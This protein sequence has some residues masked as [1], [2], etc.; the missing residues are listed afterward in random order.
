MTPD[1]NHLLFLAWLIGTTLLSALIVKTMARIGVMDNP[2]E[3]SSH[4]VPT[5][6]GG[7]IGI[8]CAFLTGSIVI[9]PLLHQPYLFSI[10]A[11]LGTV[12]FLSIIS[13][14]DDIKQWPALIKLAA[15]IICAITIT[16]IIPSLSLLQQSYFLLLPIILIWL[17]Y[18][19]NAFNFMDGLNGLA[20]G[21]AAICCIFFY[22]STHQIEFGLIALALLC[23]LI[24]FLPFNYPK[25]E[26]FM[27]DVGSQACGLLLATFAVIPLNNIDHI[28]LTTIPTETILI[29]FL[30]FGVIYDVTFTLIRRTKNRDPILQAHR[31]H[32][33]QMAHRCGVKAAIVTLVQWS[34]CIWGGVI[35]LFIPLSTMF[36]TL[37]AYSLLIVPQLIWTLF[38]LN[39]TRQY[40]IKKW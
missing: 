12:A 8:I 16:L 5:P 14:L 25:A 35:I 38:I 30:L 26:I 37:C 4:T 10:I 22:Y 34:F 15:Q 33:Y 11:L 21:I 1:T 9:F 40:H 3:R 17:V 27:G 19:V 39:K 24:G 29:F 18:I 28:T 32:L 20:A 23:G 2:V 7:G 31:S 6:K 36:N 13:W